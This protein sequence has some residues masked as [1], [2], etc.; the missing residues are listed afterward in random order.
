MHSPRPDLQHCHPMNPSQARCPAGAS[1]LVPTSS[2]PSF[3][4]QHC[5]QY[6]AKLRLL[7]PLPT[8][9]HWARTRHAQSGRCSP[10]R[11]PGRGTAASTIR[12][13]LVLQTGLRTTPPAHLR[14]RPCLNADEQSI[15]HGR[16]SST[17]VYHTSVRVYRT[18]CGRPS[19]TPV[20]HAGS[21]H[22][23][24]SQPHLDSRSHSLPDR[25]CG[26]G[27]GAVCECATDQSGQAGQADSTRARGAARRVVRVLLSPPHPPSTCQSCR[28]AWGRLL[29]EHAWRPH[30]RH[31]PLAEL[32]HLAAPPP[33][34]VAAAQ[35]FASSR[36]RLAAA[37][38]HHTVSETVEAG[39]LV[40]DVMSAVFR[41]AGSNWLSADA[42][43]RYSSDDAE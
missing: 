17:P 19:S 24:C 13:R 6:P 11:R 5:Q 16:P 15:W 2:H 43:A 29:A 27:C 39:Q 42:H 25:R 14:H 20:A 41:T 9:Q 21:T 35:S 34:P 4:H 38:V 8:Q 31:Q 28:K 26:C 33:A 12:R 1:A 30:P 36:R 3:Q 10:S 22:Q 18:R 7:Y 40:L 23:H 37:G 32:V